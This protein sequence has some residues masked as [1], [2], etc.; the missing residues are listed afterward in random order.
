MSAP[1]ILD[2]RMAVAQRK[3]GQ[4]MVVKLGFWPGD[5]SL[6]VLIRHLVPNLVDM[7]SAPAPAGVLAVPHTDNS[8]FIVN[9]TSQEMVIG[10]RRGAT[11]RLSGTAVTGQSLLKPFQVLWLE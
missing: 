3:L 7:L 6:M 5:D 4:G 11:D 1:A 9:T 10:L 8:I 2:G